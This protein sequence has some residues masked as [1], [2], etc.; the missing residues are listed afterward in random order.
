MPLQDEVV[1]THFF[2]ELLNGFFAGIIECYADDLKP[3]GSVLLLHFDKPGHLDSARPAPGR[4]EVQEHSLAAKVRQLDL[5]TFKV[6]EHE[7]GGFLALHLAVDQRF[8]VAQHRRNL[9]PTRTSHSGEDHDSYHQ[10][11]DNNGRSI[12]FHNNTPNGIIS[13]SASECKAV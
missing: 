1:N 7:I 2:R 12:T 5:L 11:Q 6:M 10:G 3:L 4:P 13:I 9:R 8:R